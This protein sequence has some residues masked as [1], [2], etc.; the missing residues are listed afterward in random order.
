M[1]QIGFDKQLLRVFTFI[2]SLSVLVSLVALGANWYL[3]GQQR[4]L[5]QNNLP[6]LSLARKISDES[7]FVAALAPS[8]SEV[9]NLDDLQGLVRSLQF[10]LDELLSDFQALDRKDAVPS[11]RD[12]IVLLQQLQTAISRLG[13]VA[14][15]RLI[16]RQ[17]LDR[18][19]IFVADILEE[20]QDLLASQLD[21]A[22]VRV[23]ATIADLYVKSGPQSRE[24]LDGLADRD[25]F[26]YDRQV[27]LGRA[28]DKAG[29]MLLRVVDLTDA[30]IL[31][32]QRTLA[33]AE[34]EFAERRLSYLVANAARARA[35]DLMA[36]LRKELLP[37]GSFARQAVVLSDGGEMSSLLVQIR[38]DVIR[39][40]NLS[41]DLLSRLQANAVRSQQRTETLGRRISVGL[42][43]LLVLATG[44]AFVSWQFARRQVVGRLRGVAQHIEALAHEEYDRD[45]PVS[46]RDEI[47]EMEKALHILRGRAAKA[48]EL[49]DELEET[50]RLR[51]GDIVTEMKAHDVARAE[52][53]DANRA[54]SEFLAMMSHEIRTPLN[55]IIGMLRLLESDMSGQGQDRKESDRLHIARL[56]AEHL[57]GLTN[58][59]LDYA[60]T[61]R[62]K[63]RAAPVHFDTRDLLGQ[64][65]TYLSVSAEA[66]GLGYGVQ[67][68][69]DL[70]FAFYGD[71]AKIRQVLVNLLSNATKYTDHGRVDLVVEHAFDDEKARHVIS[72]V[73]V[74]TGIG[75]AAQDMDY[76]FDAYGRAD[77]GQKADIQGMGLGLS[78]SRRLT[79]VIG[80]L[81]SVESEPGMGSRFSLTVSL[82][83]GDLSQVARVTE[84]SPVADLGQ[85]VLLVE[86]NAVNRMVAHG[87][88]ERLGCRVTDAATGKAALAST[89][90]GDGAAFD[91]ILLDL[92]LPDMT[93]IEVAAEI[94]KQLSNPPLM[95][96][97]TAHNISDTPEERARL[98]VARVMTKPVSPRMLREV[99]G[100]EAFVEADRETD[101]STLTALREDMEDL[102]AEE[103]AEIIGEYL[104]QLDSTVPDLLTALRENDGEAARKLSHR[105][106]GASA[107]YRLTKFCAQLA[108]IEASSADGDVLETYEDALVIS[109]DAARQTL[110]LAAKQAQLSLESQ[111][112][113]AAK[114]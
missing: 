103:T 113:D 46:G 1:R 5:I 64:L 83:E 97:L 57:L 65:G 89:I 92:D 84:T 91:V 50:V 108:E 85:H 8:F 75:I 74:D 36:L 43:L 70:P 78:I 79:E 31:G 56:S 62:D 109:A 2:V 72:F 90:K 41:D 53:E 68:P 111:T 13:E 61:E 106:K 112:S 58:D 63:M 34:L 17:G 9:G 67:V 35:V 6:A 93:G 100:G 28:I 94:T 98:G 82:P 16:Q 99:L 114:T 29:N 87:Y 45:I 7:V 3:S 71:V 23:T 77:P 96:A 95:V 15:S 76:I 102:G 59:L 42:G 110:L 33:I 55:G 48:R 49:R 86:D 27:E 11:Q 4:A 24:T 73:V 88:L 20:M 47:G 37:G 81:L 54:K 51:T 30:E 32:Q 39:L 40:T 38:K 80:G 60:S 18:Q 105:L 14:E 12:R 25:F 22:R 10:E 66:R 44:A 52:A 69:A 104:R 107:N 21:I 19:M 101:S 26:A